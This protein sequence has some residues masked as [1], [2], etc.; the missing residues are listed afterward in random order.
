MRNGWR[1]RWWRGAVAMALLA[2]LS[3]VVTA[4]GGEA[5]A[6]DIAGSGKL[7]VVTTTGQIGDMARH[8]G[9]E[10]VEVTALMGPGVDPHLYVASEGDVDRLVQAD[11][12]LYNGLFLEAQMADV[13]RQIGERKPAIPVAERIDPGQL[14]PWANYTDEFDPH[15]WF[16]VSLWMKTVDAVRD[17]L[18]EADPDNA[19]TYQANAE[20]YLAHLAELDAY[21]KQQ[22]ATLPAEKRVLVTAHDAFHYFGRAYGFEVRGLQGIST[23]SEAGTADVREL[24]DFIAER[25]IPAIFIE[26]SVPVRNVEALQAAVRDRGGEV[27]IGGQL[28]SDALGSPDSD[29]GTYIGM[30]RHNIDTIVQAL[31]GDAVGGE[32]D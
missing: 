6:S 9:G 16:D 10:L 4:C 28:Y 7:Q 23:A 25:K 31:R 27:V 30:V 13:L 32:Q 20:A 8:V 18:A 12:I 1:N 21:V 11:V 5:A 15:V 26:T 19:A 3:V 29:A 22:A 2:T 17:A 14:L 24:A